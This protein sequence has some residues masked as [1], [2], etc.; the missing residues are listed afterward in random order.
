MLGVGRAMAQMPLPAAKPTDGAMLFK[1]QCATCHTTNVSDAPR[2]GPTLFN[3]VGRDAGTAEGFRYSAGFASAKFKWDEQKLD[4][5][6]A[7]P[8]AMIAGAIMPYK[9]TRPELRIA[10][11]SYLKELH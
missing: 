5:W 2:P 1:Q 3:I 9:Q 4:Q 11:V 6:L 7:D 10:I 8:Q